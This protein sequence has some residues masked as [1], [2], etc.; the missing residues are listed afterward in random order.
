MVLT[1]VYR[2]SALLVE[3][4]LRYSDHSESC[5]ASLR[6]ESYLKFRIYHFGIERTHKGIANPEQDSG[7]PGRVLGLISNPC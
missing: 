3:A 2:I 6:P 1:G 4:I 5:L 7:N